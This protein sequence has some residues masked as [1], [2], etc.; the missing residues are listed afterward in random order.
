MASLTGRLCDVGIP[1]LAGLVVF[2]VVARLLRLKDEPGERA[3]MGKIGPVGKPIEQ[4]RR[5]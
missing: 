5:H 1:S 4:Q 3:D 2:Y